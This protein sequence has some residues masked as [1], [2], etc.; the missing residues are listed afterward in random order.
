MPKNA[1]KKPYLLDRDALHNKQDA[2][3]HGRGD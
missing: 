2:K 1:V 3:V